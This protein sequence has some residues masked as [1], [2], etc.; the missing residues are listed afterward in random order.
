M[1][2]TSAFTDVDGAE[3]DE[4][5]ARRVNVDRTREVVALGAPGRVL[6]DRLRVRRAEGRAV[7]RVGPA[8]SALGLRA[9]E[10]RGRARDPRRLDRPLLVALRAVGE[11]LRA[12]DA[13]ARPRAGR[14]VRRGRP[15]GLPNVR[16]APGR[17]DARARRRCRTARTTWP[18]TATAR[19]PS[20]PRRSSRRRAS[21]AASAGS[22]TAELGRPAPRPAYSVLRSEKPETPRLPHWRRRAA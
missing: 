17:G 18:P 10:A 3:A 8:E 16:R 11:E 12:D 7:R 21:T 15:A 9:D 4:D 20:S 1:L 22:T 19:G 14:G 2:H 6:L 5:G 13:R